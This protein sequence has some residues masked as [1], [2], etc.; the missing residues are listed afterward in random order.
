MAADRQTSV[1]DVLH[2][3][4]DALERQQFLRGLNEDYARLRQDPAEW[5]KYRDELAE[6]DSLA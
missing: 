3:A 6:W 5:Q 4:V 1:I 2:H